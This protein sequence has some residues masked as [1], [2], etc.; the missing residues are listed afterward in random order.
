MIGRSP[1]WLVDVPFAHRGLHGDGIPENSLAAFAAAADAGYGIELD[2]QQTADGFPVIVH[3]VTL[4]RVAGAPLRPH[5]LSLAELAQLRLGETDHLVPTLAD[6]LDVIGGRTPVMVELKNFGRRT[7][8]LE[9]R[10]AAILDGYRGPLCLS[11]FNP[12]TIAWLRRT[13]PA[14]LRG[15]AAGTLDDVPMPRWLRPLLRRMAWNRWNQPDFVAYELVALPH[16]AVDRARRDGAAVVAWTVSNDD[17]LERARQLADNI[18]FEE[19]R[20]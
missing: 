7:G 12:R 11:S 5:D 2:V 6:A 18:I 14:W 10:V 4:E 15:Q 9:G 13:R 20:P 17:D 19:V 8:G 1:A 16:P 3:D